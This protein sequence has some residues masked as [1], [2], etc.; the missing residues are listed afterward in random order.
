[1]VH[2]IHTCLVV[3]SAVLICAF[4]VM[5]KD[6][7][8]IACLSPTFHAIS[9]FKCSLTD[10]LIETYQKATGKKK[11]ILKSAIAIGRRGPSKLK[12]AGSE[13]PCVGL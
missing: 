2:A 9:A 10:T 6:A 13:S 12:L 5:D 11:V 7:H 3:L 4:E 8:V 1:M